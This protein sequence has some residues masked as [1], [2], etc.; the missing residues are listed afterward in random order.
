MAMLISKS[1]EFPLRDGVG[2]GGGG[3]KGKKATCMPSNQTETFHLERGS[4]TSPTTTQY[5]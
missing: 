1:N 4:V 3:N 5:L 2:G